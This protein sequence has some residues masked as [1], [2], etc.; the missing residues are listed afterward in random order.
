VFE[1]V[2][3]ESPLPLSL[4]LHI[5]FCHVHCTYCAF[6]IATRAEAYIPA[7]VAAMVNELRLLG[8]VPQAPIHTIYF[9]GGTP[10][11]LSTEQV[12]QIITACCDSFVVSPDAEITLE[13]NPESLSTN[14]L[15]A[16]RAAGVNRLSIGMQSARPEDLHLFARQHDLNDVSLAVRGARKAGFTNV[17]LDLIYGVPGQTLAAWRE[18]LEAALALGPDH[19]SL[20][21]LSLEQGT[22]LNRAV[23]RG[24]KLRP[25]DDLAAD[26]YEL[27]DGLLSD[28]G[29]AQYEISSWARPAAQARHNL[30]YW[31]NLPYL[32]VGA[33][34]HGYA[35]GLRY[36]VVRPFK[37]YIEHAAA[38]ENPLPFP[39]TETV[40]RVE[41]IDLR[42]AMS[43]H[44]I[45]GLRL[46]NEGI[47]IPGF[48]ARFGVP[49]E[50]VFGPALERLVDYGMLYTCENSIRLT[51]RARLVSNQVFVYFM[52]EPTDQPE[53]LALVNSGE[54]TD[55]Y[56]V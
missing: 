52:P 17:S 50:A 43:E 4:Y 44:M 14:Y 7:Y 55:V 28:T 8:Q 20:Y 48:Q 37:Q 11:L 27:A 29:L 13:A 21:A 46:L 33:G 2:T 22:A 15:A 25:D 18:S 1:H 40:E 56:H 31:R 45:T 39:L 10:S 36:E 12:S 30:Q 16:L 54:S 23:E 26:M 19:L 35:A 53:S 6:N 49:I 41:P 51:Q 5:P 24:W 34:A 32:G 38:Q 3:N 47:S 9:G 42:T